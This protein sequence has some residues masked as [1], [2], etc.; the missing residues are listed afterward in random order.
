MSRGWDATGNRSR[1]VSVS[2]LQGPSQVRSILFPCPR[3]MLGQGRCNS[4][5]RIR[6]TQRRRNHVRIWTWRFGLIL[7]DSA[8]RWPECEQHELLI[9]AAASLGWFQL[10]RD[11]NGRMVS[12]AVLNLELLRF[13]SIEEHHSDN[14]LPWK[15][16]RPPQ[17]HFRNGLRL[18]GS[19]LQVWRHCLARC[20]RRNI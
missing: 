20:V 8:S 15:Q 12:R 13:G 11:G 18:N 5:A 17:R 1:T 19:R 7:P 14:I 16:C 9:A 4:L 3:E 6:G 2:F 10:L